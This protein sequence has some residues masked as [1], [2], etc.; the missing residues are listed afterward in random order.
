MTEAEIGTF[1]LTDFLLTHFDRLILRG[2]GLDKHPS[3]LPVYFGNRNWDPF[4]EGTV[5]QMKN[6]M[7]VGN[8][9][10][11]VI[12]ADGHLGYAQPVGGVIAYEKQISVSGVGFEFVPS[13]EV[14]VPSS[15]GYGMAAREWNGTPILLCENGVFQVSGEGPDNTGNPSSWDR[16]PV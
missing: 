4:I 8:A 6:C 11:G 13:Y 9:V 16:S 1:Y 14:I 3:L 2:L 10:A 15:G 7:T 12:C 5:A